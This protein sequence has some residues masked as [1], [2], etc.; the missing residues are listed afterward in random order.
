[1]QSLKANKGGTF[2]E[3]SKC[4][5]ANYLDVGEANFQ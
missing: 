2:A 3:S 1:V 5:T 4:R